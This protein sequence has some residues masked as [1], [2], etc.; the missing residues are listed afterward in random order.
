MGTTEKIRAVRSGAT[1]SRY[2]LEQ[3]DHWHES[4][5]DVLGLID[6]LGQAGCI[7]VD[8]DGWLSA[9]QCVMVAFDPAGRVVGQ[10]CFRVEP[11]SVDGK[12]VVEA[13]KVVM[14]AKVDC[15]GV[16]PGLDQ[17]EVLSIL[18]EV[19]EQQARSLGCREFVP[20]EACA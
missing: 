14:R 20:A 11:I 10:T 4:W 17:N 2:C 9:R 1:G 8:A 19:S 12:F 15:Q 5:P 13:G 6:R 7:L 16:E 18:R 3:V